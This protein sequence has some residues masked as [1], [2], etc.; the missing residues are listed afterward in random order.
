MPTSRRATSHFIEDHSGQVG[1]GTVL[2]TCIVEVSSAETPALVHQDTFRDSSWIRSRP[3]QCY[4]V[5][6]ATDL[7][8]M[9]RKKAHDWKCCDSSR[10]SQD[11]IV[12]A[13]LTRCFININPPIASFL[14]HR[15]PHRKVSRPLLYLDPCLCCVCRS[16]LNLRK[17]HNIINE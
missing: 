6:I 1:V 15:T 4:L 13:H 3:L 16:I 17:C 14:A 7:L 11:G 5:W 10:G 8:K 9:I 12:E 2:C